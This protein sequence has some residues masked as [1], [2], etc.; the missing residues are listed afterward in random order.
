MYEASTSLTSAFLRDSSS[1]G[2]ADLTE[3]IIV[4]TAFVLP[5]EQQP[6]RGRILVFEI[7]TASPSESGR[8]VS[9]VVETPTRGAAYSLASIQGRVVAGVDSKV[10]I[11]LMNSS[12]SHIDSNLSIRSN[13]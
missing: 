10:I 5:E 2:S 11:N 1:S 4:G 9:L 8:K 12:Q 7:S 6:S 13:W 3:Y